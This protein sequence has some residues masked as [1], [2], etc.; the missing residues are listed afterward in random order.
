VD[1]LVRVYN[2]PEVQTQLRKTLAPLRQDGIEEF[3]TRRGRAVIERVSAKDLHAAD[4]AEIQDLT[5]EE[6]LTWE[7]KRSPEDAICLG[8]S[9][10]TVHRSMPGD[11]KLVKTPLEDTKGLPC[12]PL[13]STHQMDRSR[14]G[15]SQGLAPPKWM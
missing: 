8:N 5:K 10:M 13:G 3:Q 2:D 12:G 11:W 6:E 7:L 14:T 9:A 4:E 1:L 15:V